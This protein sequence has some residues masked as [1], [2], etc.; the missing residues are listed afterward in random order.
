MVLT[1][2]LCFRKIRSQSYCTGTNFKFKEKNHSINSVYN[3]ALYI[4]L[5]KTLLLIKKIPN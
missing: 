2:K 1:E 5:E 4:D 3:R